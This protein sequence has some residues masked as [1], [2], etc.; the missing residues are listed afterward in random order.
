[1]T[2]PHDD[3]K[4]DAETRACCAKLQVQLDEVQ[5]QLAQARSEVD[6]LLVELSEERKNGLRLAQEFEEERELWQ[7]ESTR[8]REQF[9]R[10]AGSDPPPRHS[11]V[12][13]RDDAKQRESADTVRPPPVNKR[14]G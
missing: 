5:Q 10:V 4:L 2:P 6:Q 12:V 11:L 3:P 1:M 14:S 9:T 7:T 13:R 8:L